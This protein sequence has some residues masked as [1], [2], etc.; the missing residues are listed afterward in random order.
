MLNAE[1]SAPKYIP[2][3]LAQTSICTFPNE[4]HFSLCW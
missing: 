2:A 1:I 4:I 3:H